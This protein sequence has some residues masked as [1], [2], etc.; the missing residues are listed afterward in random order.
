MALDMSA[1]YRDDATP[2]ETIKAYQHLINTGSCW[3]M[4]GSTGRYAM[5]LLKGGFCM[6]GE[7]GHQNAYGGYVPSRYEVKPGTL[8]SREY[9]NAKIRERDEDIL[10]ENCY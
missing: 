6:L 9:M 3:T 1:I 5:E 7:T 8:G 4:D 2:D 10:N